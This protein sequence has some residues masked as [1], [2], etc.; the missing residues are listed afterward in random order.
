MTEISENIGI[1][2]SDWNFFLEF[3][4][5]I[6]NMIRMERYVQGTNYKLLRV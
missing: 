5:E 6:E 1:D 2:V 4:K 3:E